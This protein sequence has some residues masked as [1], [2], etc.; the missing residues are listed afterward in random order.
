MFNINESGQCTSYVKQND[1]IK[2]NDFFS[3]EAMQYSKR[4]SLKKNTENIFAKFT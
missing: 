3:F 1:S 4:I 2:A